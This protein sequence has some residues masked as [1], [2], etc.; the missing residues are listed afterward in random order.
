MIPVIIHYITTCGKKLAGKTNTGGN[1]FWN[2]LKSSKKFVTNVENWINET[3]IVFWYKNNTSL[4]II[5]CL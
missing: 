1:I 5:M 3:R 4:Q 2:M